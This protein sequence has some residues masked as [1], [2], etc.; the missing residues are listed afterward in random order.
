MSDEE[1]Q[2]FEK[3]TEQWVETEILRFIRAVLKA[4]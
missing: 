2:E 1:I 4:N 3:V